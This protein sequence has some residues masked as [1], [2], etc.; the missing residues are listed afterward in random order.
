MGE[1]LRLWLPVLYYLDMLHLSLYPS[2]LVF[3]WYISHIW[4]FKVLRFSVIREK[5]HQ[6]CTPC[7]FSYSY[8]VRNPK[9]NYFKS[10]MI[11]VRPAYILH[12]SYP[13]P[14]LSSSIL[15]KRSVPLLCKLCWK[16][17][18]SCA[19]GHPATT[20]HGLCITR[21]R[22]QTTEGW[23]VPTGL[24]LAWWHS[25]VL[26]SSC[27]AKQDVL[28]LAFGAKLHHTS[29]VCVRSSKRHHDVMRYCI[30]YSKCISNLLIFFIIIINTDRL[31]KHASS[32]IP[33]L[34]PQDTR[35]MPKLESIPST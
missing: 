34:V 27:S 9:E 33:F 26:S 19:G 29:R 6:I 22:V 21:E 5:K 4:D 10:T 12:Y 30:W 11:S 35:E 18:S 20:V 31:Y 24:T 14:S 16:S 1:G 13:S 28:N 23:I 15:P 32:V 2:V 17:P 7:V 3:G 25:F 8:L